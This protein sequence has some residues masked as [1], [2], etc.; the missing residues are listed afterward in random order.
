ML[1]ALIV[2][3][4]GTIADDRHRRC[5]LDVEKWGKREFD[6]YYEAMD[7]DDVFKWCRDLVRLYLEKRYCIIFIT[8]RPEDYRQKTVQWLFAKV[9]L[10]PDTHYK[11]YMRPKDCYRPDTELKAE[12]YEEHVKGKYDV[13]FVLDDRTRVV[14]MWRQLGLVCLQV[15]PSNF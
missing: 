6:K 7:K 5:F 12:A 9:G 3:L 13:E 1:K 2:D 10:N 15:A 4:D 11:L 8:G 14:E